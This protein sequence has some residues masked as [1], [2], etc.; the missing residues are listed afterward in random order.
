MLLRTKAQLSEAALEVCMRGEIGCKLRQFFESGWGEIYFYSIAKAYY[1]SFVWGEVRE[2]ENKEWM[3]SW[4]EIGK[5][6]VCETASRCDA[7]VCIR[8]CLG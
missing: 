1:T 7:S 4:S 6:V 8:M 2:I 5:W 3:L